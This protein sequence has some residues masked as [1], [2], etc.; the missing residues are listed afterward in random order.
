MLS[1]EKVN[2]SRSVLRSVRF[3]SARVCMGYNQRLVMGLRNE[4]G[5][6]EIQLLATYMVFLLTI[7][8]FIIGL[9]VGVWKQAEAKYL[10]FA[11][12]MDFAAQAANMTGNIEEVMLNEGLAKQY[13]KLA[14]DEMLDDYTLKSFSAVDTDYPVPGGT[15][16]SPGY[17]AT[18][19][20]P[21]FE[22]Y[23]PL[24]GRQQVRIPM[25]YFAVVE[26]SQIN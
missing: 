10:W 3:N 5:F 4:N 12:A 20:V 17:V 14:M 2:S 21:V 11:E 8:C 22:G 25:R 16:Q 24:V 18:I 26:S 7:F 19:T 23:V 6:I 15:A 9:G 1:G 13:F